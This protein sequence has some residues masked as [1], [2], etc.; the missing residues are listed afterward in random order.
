MTKYKPR[1]R[2]IK[3]KNLLSSSE[4]D[5]GQEEEDHDVSDPFIK[6]RSR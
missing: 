4:G 2:V 5:T 1:K 3:E 6:R